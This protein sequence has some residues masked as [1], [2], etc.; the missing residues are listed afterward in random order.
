MASIAA[1]S[2]RYGVVIVKLDGMNCG[3]NSV[4]AALSS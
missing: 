1:K 3:F 4:Y 2:I